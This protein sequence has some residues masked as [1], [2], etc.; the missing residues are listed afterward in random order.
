VVGPGLAADGGECGG[1]GALLTGLRPAAVVGGVVVG[2]AV[3]AV[4]VAAAAVRAACWLGM[5]AIGRRVPG[6]RV[7]RGLP[8][9]ATS[10][11][12]AGRAAVAGLRC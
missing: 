9:A 8:P 5:P 1:G 4:R 2:V 3:R 10:A 12:L 11:L 7:S 6:G